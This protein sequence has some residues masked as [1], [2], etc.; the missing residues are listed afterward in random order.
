ME[1]FKIFHFKSL[2]STQDKAKEF[3]KEGQSNVV[4][5][6]D[7]QTRGR[8]RF[9]RKWHSPNGGL[10][11]SILLK[12][13]NIGN[14]HYLTFASAVAVAESIKKITNV[15][16]NIK[17]PND[18]H[19]KKKKLCGILT[20]GLFGKDSYIAVGI[21]LNLN[22]TRFPA[23]IKNAA[24]SLRNIKKKPIDIKKIMDS[25]IG[26][27]LFLYNNHY[28]KNNFKKILHIWKKYCDTIGKDAIICTKTKKIY[29]RVLDVDKDCSLL[30][31]LK[32]NKIIKIAE[33]DINVR[34]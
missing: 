23:E 26:E 11:M 8:G 17:W 18:V 2:T 24:T 28:N 12:P 32:N 5:C 20:E 19:Y 9:K 33:G 15:D 7:T 16:T 13:K 1:P 4:I 3:A 34:Y 21:G 6:A 29:G 25:I 14:I 31:K 27:F 22:Q 10:W 30:L